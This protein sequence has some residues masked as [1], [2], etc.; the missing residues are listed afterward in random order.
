MSRSDRPLRIGIDIRYLSHGL[1]GGVHTYVARLVP[2]LLSAAPE[3]EF[4]LYADTKASL[5][6]DSPGSAVVRL[7]PWRGQAS[8]VRIDA[9]L[10]RRMGDDRI[11][12]A[13]FPANYGFGPPDAATVITLHDAINL[14]PLTYQFGRRSHTQSLRTSLMMVYLHMTTSR[15]ARRATRLITMSEYSRQ[16][17]TEASGRQ[18]SEI[19]VVFHGAP[20]AVPLTPA[21][22]ATALAS[23]GIATSYVLADGL[24]NPGVVLRAAA[25]MAPE[26]RRAH[27]F[28]FFAR[29]A[30]VLPVLADAVAKGEAKL[31]VCPPTKTLAAL[32]AGASAF[33]FPSWVEGFGIPLLEAMRYGTPIVASNRGAIPEVAGDAARILDAEDDA[34][35][36]SA[37][38]EVLTRPDVAER[39][40][41]AGRDRVDTFTWR[42]SAELTLATFARAWAERDRHRENGR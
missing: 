29:H 25:R 28:V 11:D 27:T 24:K 3:H 10:G 26:I 17:I 34:G 30:G 15:A 20:P 9:T 12:V 21:D 18:P 36:A 14:L 19:D 2:A 22:I 33:A 1:V 23:H 39:L 38:Q 7:L 31:I 42:R 16:T 35:W 41:R 13:F 37:L 6:L 32:Y 5:E 40:R 4:V 8:S